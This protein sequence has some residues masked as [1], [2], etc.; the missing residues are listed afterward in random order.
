MSEFI[1]L[2]VSD[3]AVDPDKATH[4]CGSCRALYAVPESTWNRSNDAPAD[5]PG[6]TQ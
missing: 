3:L 4:Q 6:S 1:G 2:Q 5:H